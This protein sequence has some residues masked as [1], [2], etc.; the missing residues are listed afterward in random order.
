MA[1]TRNVDETTTFHCS[2]VAPYNSMRKKIRTTVKERLVW[3]RYIHEIEKQKRSL[4]IVR[5]C[6]YSYTHTSTRTRVCFALIC[7]LLSLRDDYRKTWVHFVRRVYPGLTV[8]AWHQGV[9][10]GLFTDSFSTS[11]LSVSALLRGVDDPADSPGQSRTEF[12]KIC[13]RKNGSGLA[14]AQAILPST[15]VIGHQQTPP[16]RH[17]WQ[18]C[19]GSRYSGV[20]STAWIE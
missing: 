18:L 4:I 5:L 7:C 10:H 20:L 19:L 11:L 14:G 16:C 9:C 17:A 6:R 13:I 2:T 15:V 3:T 12:A 8:T 1:C